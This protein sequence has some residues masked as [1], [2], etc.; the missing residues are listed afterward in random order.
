[1]IHFEKRG[2]GSPVVLVHGLGASS[3]SWRNTVT[4]LE[5]RYTTYAVDLIGFGRSP[6]EE[7]F[8][9]TMAAQAEALSTFIRGQGLSKPDLVGHSM[10]GGV[11]LHLAAEAGRGSWPSVG[12]MVLVAPVAY[13]PA[14]AVPGINFGGVAALS[15]PGGLGLAATGD[16]QAPQTKAIARSL[17]EHFLRSVCARSATI[18]DE[19]IEG[20]GEGLSSI[21]QIRA[22]ISHAR[23]IGQIAVPPGG[24]SAIAA[25]TL[26]IWGE[27]DPLVSQQQVEDLQRAIAAAE[28]ERISR[29]G[30]IPHEEHPAKVNRLI[31]TFLA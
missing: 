17:A 24:L 26:I 18:T 14:S 31:S 12:K 11:C 16:M 2:S 9:S 5:T 10:G 1:M 7:S 4:E 25:E 20:Y 29:C 28:L 13:P 30:H 27:E 3:F 15:A 21:G 23:N 8:P 19:Q 22:F 6:A